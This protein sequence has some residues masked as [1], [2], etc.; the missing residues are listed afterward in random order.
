MT[1]GTGC[2]ASHG[3]VGTARRWWRCL[4]CCSRRERLPGRSSSTEH[5]ARARRDAR[6]PA[7]GLSLRPELLLG[8]S[9]GEKQGCRPSRQG[10]GGLVGTHALMQESVSFTG[11]PRRHRRADRF[12]VDSAPADRKAGADVLLL[13]ATPIRAR[14]LTLLRDLD[15]VDAAPPALAGTV[16]RGAHAARE[17]H[18][19]V[20]AS[21]EGRPAYVVLPVIEESS[22]GSPGGHHDGA[23]WRRVVRARVGL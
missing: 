3:D 19:V 11:R 4:P 7:R 1:R 16:R 23:S 6:A 17:R 5:L 20:R 22:G 14:P 18:G 13:T 10:Q 2:T 12:G 21:R 9:A 15:V 8:G